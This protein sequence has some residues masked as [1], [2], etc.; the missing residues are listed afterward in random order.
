M[1]DH[2]TNPPASTDAQHAG[3]DLLDVA[4]PLF[5]H[6]KMLI[7]A[8]LLTGLVAL[9]ATYLIAPTYTARTAFVPAQQQSAAATA[10]SSVGAL[11]G[12]AG[13]AGNTAALR[14]PAE[15]FV[16]LMQSS[17][18]A[19][20]IVDKFELM[21]IY[22]TKLRVDARKELGENVRITVGKKDGLITVEVDDE[23]PERAAA[24][25]NQ[26]VEELRALTARLAL[27]EAQQRRVF[28][29]AQLQQTRDRLTHAQQA[30]EASGFSQ[31]ALKAEPKAAAENYARLRAEATAGEVRLQ[32]L[33]RN[34]AEGSFEVQQQFAALSALRMQLSKAEA[35]T[36]I[37]DA[38]DYVS[39][40]REF[41]Y[42]ETLFELFARQYELARLDE[43]REGAL[44]Q[45]VDTA[46]P[47]ER[48]SSPKR[49]A[50]AIATTLGA[51][52][53]IACFL[54]S[55]H[56]WRELA[57]RPATAAKISRLRAAI[58]AR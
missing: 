20:R 10:L 25:A 17:T 19:D 29:G 47:P 40:Y 22:D 26:F 43:S 55:R 18:V 21:S 52:F 14:S 45:V 33:R 8:P 58:R 24:I 34:L 41:K 39:K 15:Q 50:T 7:V 42:Q 9:G 23:Y 13:L 27:T 11:A 54:V 6:V 51:L 57:A 28:F 1:L 37:A 2:P 44:I 53:F 30:L 46:A 38:P 4:L 56:F 36:D 31:G 16:A 49:G 3:A 32:T 12:L 5:M 48:K 35:S